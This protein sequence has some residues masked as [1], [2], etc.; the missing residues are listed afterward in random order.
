MITALALVAGLPVSV[1]AHD[2]PSPPV[3]LTSVPTMDGPQDLPGRE[4]GPRSN[5]PAQQM[6]GAAKPEPVPATPAPVA[7]R[8]WFGYK[9]FLEWEH[10]TGDWNGARASM[11]EAGVSFAGSLEI[12]FG[13]VLEGGLRRAFSA[14]Y[15]LDGA[16]TLDMGKIA[17]I[18]GGKVYLDAYLTRVDG[19]SRDTGDIQGIS[20][21]DSGD[22]RGQVGEVWWEQTLDD[23]KVRFKIGKIDAN[24]EF[25]F[26]G[27]SSYNLHAAAAMTPAVAATAAFPDPA[28]GAVLF[29]Y[30]C[31]HFYAGGGVFDGATLDGYPTGERGPQTFFSD[32][33]SS[34]WI[35]C[36]ETGVTWK[37]LGD[38]G[39]G[40]VSVGFNHHTGEFERFDGGTHN[41]STALYAIAE[42][43]LWQ[44]GKGEEDADRGVYAFLQYGHGESSVNNVENHVGLGLT[45][46]GCMEQRPKDAAGVY[47]SWVDLSDAP[48]SAFAKNETAVEAFYQWQLTP[49]IAVTPALTWVANPG[50]SAT[51]DDALA[52]QV[53]VT[54][55]F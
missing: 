37:S 33:D 40:R 47:C 17:S 15:M 23:K 42:Q 7:E 27:I 6:P 26:P 39:K 25:F 1:F 46:V 38:M 16:V 53:R 51:V 9:P 43:Q 31:E 34:S 12:H 29:V 19:G 22:D 20:N 52:W 48:G 45:C 8:E 10:L 4:Q 3:E 50:G 41:G 36:G 11:E 30:P 44:A 13:S 28:F 32:N 49:A 5:D 24:S 21:I 54:I 14:R 2:E 18:A 55:A 35:F